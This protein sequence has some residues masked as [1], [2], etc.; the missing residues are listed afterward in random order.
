M[1]PNQAPA[2]TPGN[3]AI[4]E[5]T[6]QRE[7]GQEV[8]LF[9]DNQLHRLLAVQFGADQSRACRRNAAENLATLRRSALNLL[10]RDTTKQR[11]ICGK[12]KKTCWN[13]RDLIHLLGL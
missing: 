13:Q 9:V 5:A 7:R 3:Q 6:A 10:K 1:P 11:G 12:Q 2:Y 4:I 8:T